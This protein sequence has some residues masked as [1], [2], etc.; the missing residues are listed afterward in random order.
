M[1]EPKV[2]LVAMNDDEQE[3]LR[4][5]FAHEDWETAVVT[6]FDEATREISES[7]VQ[8]MFV[9]IHGEIE[10]EESEIRYLKDKVGPSTSLVL[11]T[12]DQEFNAEEVLT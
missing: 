4:D 8:L 9:S 12:D 10:D 1:S 3:E 11:I 6:D 5:A 2:L 7:T